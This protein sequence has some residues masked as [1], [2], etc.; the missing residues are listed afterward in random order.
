MRVV[1]NANP[2]F[3]HVR[4]TARG[5]ASEAASESWFVQAERCRVAVERSLP[6]ASVE[7]CFN[8]GPVGRHLFNEGIPRPLSPRS[9]WVV[10]PHARPLLI[11]K[12]VVDCDMVGVRLHPGTAEQVLGVPPTELRE[13]LVDLDTLW[14]P[15]VET[16]RDRLHSAGDARRR[17]AIV[18]EVIAARLAMGR[19]PAEVTLVRRLCAALRATP[20]ASVATVAAGHG[21]SHRRMIA[22][23]DRNVGLKPKECQRVERLRRVIT[24]VHDEPRPLWT[25]IAHACGYFDQPHLINDFRVQAGITPGEYVT[26]RTSV[27]SGFV[28]YRFANAG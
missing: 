4:Q 17:L 9:A 21:L 12:E 28:P 27:G 20:S 25:R 23:F 22:L 13:G 16:I 2:R 14:G 1:T 15:V 26:T 18:E 5:A 3:L 24:M 11:E 8:L 6:D 7:L 10:G 19:R